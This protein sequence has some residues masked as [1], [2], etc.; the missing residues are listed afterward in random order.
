M[1]LFPEYLHSHSPGALWQEV[2]PSSD[3]ISSSSTKLALL[4][5]PFK[6]FCN[7]HRKEIL[8]I[9]PFSF[10]DSFPIIFFHYPE[11]LWLK[12]DSE[13]LDILGLFL[14]LWGRVMGTSVW[15]VLLAHFN[16]FINLT[17][18]VNIRAS[19]TTFRTVYVV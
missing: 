16:H 6:T 7:S 8:S 11:L 19:P 13:K 5:T 10:N 3:S 1:C 15:M 2:G 9:L 17:A 4:S 12:K 14:V 18:F